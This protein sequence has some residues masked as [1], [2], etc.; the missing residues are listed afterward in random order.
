VGSKAG[1]DILEKRKM[2]C[3][4]REKNDAFSVAQPVA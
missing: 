2:Y 3:V 4:S 1:M